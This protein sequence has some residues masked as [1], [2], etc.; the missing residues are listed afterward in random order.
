MSKRAQ[1]CNN[2]GQEEEDGEKKQ[3]ATGLNCFTMLC[4]QLGAGIE[5]FLSGWFLLCYSSQPP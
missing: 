5:A 3:D 4:M 1:C 2:G